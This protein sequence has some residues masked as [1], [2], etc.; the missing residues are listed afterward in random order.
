MNKSKV[1]DNKRFDDDYL[2]NRPIVSTGQVE[3][4][5]ATGR[6]EEKVEDASEVIGHDGHD[7][8]DDGIDD[9]KIFAPAGPM[10]VVVEE[11]RPWRASLTLDVE[12]MVN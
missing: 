6:E 12:H 7:E 1:D 9:D 8:E 10:P 11:E 3:M 5:T 4:T 2:M